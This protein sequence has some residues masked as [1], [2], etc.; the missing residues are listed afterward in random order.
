MPDVNTH[1]AGHR[2]VGR[3]KG[4]LLLNAVLLLVL[5]AVTFSPGADAQAHL[6]GEYL[7]AAGNAKGANAGIVYIVDKVNQEMVAVTYDHN[8]RDLAGVGYR[9]LAAD[10]GMGRQ[11]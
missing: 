3:C 2:L 6:R 11:N 10:A 8:V 5:V 4:L 1:D 7:M 9:N